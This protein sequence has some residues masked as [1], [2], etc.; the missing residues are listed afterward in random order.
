ME[1]PLPAAST[2]GAVLTVAASA[3]DT[4]GEV[5]TRLSAVV[6]V[7]T[8]QLS[9]SFEGAAPSADSTTMGAMGVPDLGHL[10]LSICGSALAAPFAV[11]VDLPKSLQ[12]RTDARRQVC[13]STLTL[14][15]TASSSVGSLK[16]ALE[17]VLGV[18]VAQQVLTF[19]GTPL[20][21]DDAALSSVSVSLSGRLRGCAV[22]CAVCFQAFSPKTHPKQAKQNAT[23][24]PVPDSRYAHPGCQW[25][26]TFAK[27]P[28]GEDPPQW[29]WGQKRR[30][31]NAAKPSDCD[32]SGG[33]F[34]EYEMDFDSCFSSSAAA[35]VKPAE[36]KHVAILGKQGS[37]VYAATRS[38]LNKET[39]DSAGASSAYC[40]V[41]YCMDNPGYSR[42]FSE[43]CRRPRPIPPSLATDRIPTHAY[44]CPCSANC[45]T[46]V[47]VLRVHFLTGVERYNSRV[48]RATASIS[49]WWRSV[50]ASDQLMEV[51]GVLPSAT[52]FT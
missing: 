40:V 5:K 33:L 45:R 30:R 22:D 18:A 17:G 47:T 46:E 19:N 1:L 24:D 28:R 2:F 12:V 29:S 8:S 13:S 44:T 15:T 10:T 43:R 27:A 14:A 37:L 4:V 32:S 34:D 49:V 6:G 9:L 39:L 52:A 23:A 38:Y 50:W 41:H 20:V 35:E 21:P 26:K 16:R 48:V 11:K 25:S 3:D 36:V 51:M 31:D 42:C 7:G